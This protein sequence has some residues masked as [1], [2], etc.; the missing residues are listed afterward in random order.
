MTIDRREFVKGFGLAMAGVGANPRVLMNEINTVD[1]L[2]IDMIFNI[3]DYGA[4]RDNVDPADEMTDTLALE[5]AIDAAS[6]SPWGGV[7]FFPVGTY[8]IKRTIQMPNNVS[9]MGSGWQSIIRWDFDQDLFRWG[10]DDSRMRDDGRGEVGGPEETSGYYVSDR[11]VEI[12]E[13]EEEED[14]PQEEEPEESVTGPQYITISN[15]HI[16]S[17]FTYS[18]QNENSWHCAFEMRDSCSFVTFENILI[19]GLTANDHP[20]SCIR[21]LNSDNGGNSNFINNVQISNCNFAKFRGSG[22][23]IGRGAEVRISDCRL[24]GC[25]PHH[26]NPRHNYTVGIELYG[27][28]GGV[29]ITNSSIETCKYG[30]LTH[31]KEYNN[32]T[33]PGSNRELFVTNTAIDACWRGLEVIDSCYISLS[34]VWLSSCYREN[35]HVGRK[36]NNKPQITISGGTIFNCGANTDSDEEDN[37]YRHGMVVNAGHFSLTGVRINKNRGYGVWVPNTEV[38]KYTI[39]GCMIDDA[40]TNG[41]GKGLKLTGSC[42]TVIGNVIS[43]GD[44]SYE[45]TD[46]IVI[47][48][49]EC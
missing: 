32:Y 34:G 12:D 37:N 13:S 14:E 7:V 33:P 6:A 16:R 22:I 4:D 21:I 47:N 41:Q 45:G 10:V 5:A 25:K 24:V 42:Y 36:D 38:S 49:V 15:L 26:A 31:V 29:Y 2:P 3:M 17:T 19:R 28:M 11:R 43:A 40:G 1:E 20:P 9:L 44:N 35:I 23:L 8:S 39:T 46:N 48:N 30:I 18:D 27:D